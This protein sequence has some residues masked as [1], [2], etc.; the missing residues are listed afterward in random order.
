MTVTEIGS[1]PGAGS[2]SIDPV[3]PG[4]R[5]RLRYWS[6]FLGQALSLVGSA[7]TQFVLMWWITEATGSVAEL[8]TAGLAALLP[9]ALLGPIGG[10]F[11]DRY[12]RR[13]LM[14]GADAVS[15]LCMA[16]LIVLFLNDRIELWHIYAMLFIRSAMQAFQ[17]PAALASTSLLVPRRF[18]ARAAGLGQTLEGV[19][20]VAAAP[21]GAL[22]LSAMPIGWALAID[23]VTAVLG[24]VPLL[25]FTIPQP[26]EPRQA[27]SNLWTEFRDGVRAV[28]G[29]AG[30][31]DLFLLQ[32]AVV[33]VLMPSAT[34]VPLLVTQHFGGGAAQ[35]AVMEALWG[36]GM[37]VGGLAVTAWAPRRHIRWILGGFAVSCFAF[38]ASAAMPR[39][40]FTLALAWWVLSGATFVLG[41]APLTAL[42]QTTVPHHLQGRVLSLMNTV[43][44]LAAPVGLAFATPL[45]EWMGIR[46]LFVA[47]GIAG[48][49]VS[50]AGFASGA[51]RR[52]DRH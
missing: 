20:F 47:T 31:R 8:A 2:H 42:L 6:I 7:L 16:V 49:L 9:Q 48:G 19:M 45:G 29:N 36:I 27:A 38:A 39:E 30:L 44:A 22:A 17:A 40:F 4:Q 12:S 18:L 41:E 21:L 26:G 1:Q 24:I 15:A 33:L 46:G 23:V 3:G 50:L 14:I 34:L 5:W 13:L 52:L 11:A 10:L 25:V 32:A 35:V 51:L 37:L 28:A 43:I